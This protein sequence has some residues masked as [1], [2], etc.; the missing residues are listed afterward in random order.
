M[1]ICFLPGTAVIECSAQSWNYSFKTENQ[2]LHKVQTYTDAHAGC[3][4]T[5]FSPNTMKAPNSEKSVIL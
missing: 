3:M 5:H 1:C 4:W 2:G